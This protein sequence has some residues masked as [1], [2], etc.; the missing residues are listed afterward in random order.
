MLDD[1]L[2]HSGLS[3]EDADA[4][5]KGKDSYHGLFLLRTGKSKKNT[6]T[7]SV[8]YRTSKPFLSH[9][10]TL[11]KLFDGFRFFLADVYTC[12]VSE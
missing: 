11:V 1:R 3:A 10:C 8:R 4:Y 9:S 2:L 5:L 12:G 7:I 6:F